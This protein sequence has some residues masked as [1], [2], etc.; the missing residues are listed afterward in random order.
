MR[1]WEKEIDEYVR[2]K[3]KLTMNCETIYLLIIG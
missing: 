1:M 2:R 3:A